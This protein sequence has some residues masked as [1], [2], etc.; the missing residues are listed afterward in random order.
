MLPNATTKMEDTI[1]HLFALFIAAPIILA[2]IL[3]CRIKKI[4]SKTTRKSKMK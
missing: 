1:V 4:M 3:G 2:I